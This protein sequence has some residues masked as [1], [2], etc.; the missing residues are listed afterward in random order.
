MSVVSVGSFDGVHAGHR[1]IMSRM[2]FLREE[3][4]IRGLG[5]GAK[6]VVVTFLP[7]P[8]HY[9]NPDDDFKLLN[10]IEEKARLVESCGIDIMVVAR[11]DEAFMNT[12]SAQ[13][14]D[15]LRTK[16]SMK[17]LMAGYNHRLGCDGVGGEQGL[18]ALSADY[19][20]EVEVLPEFFVGGHKVSSTVVRKAIISGDMTLAADLLGSPYGV[21]LAQNDLQNDKIFICEQ[22]LLPPDGFYAARVRD[23]G[24]NVLVDRL[25]AGVEGQAVA[26]DNHSSLVEPS[27]TNDK[28]VLEFL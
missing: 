23:L 12:T 6:T 26:L 21:E 18:K 22:K 27:A 19:G 7:H 24:G 20:V 10:T 1:A 17:V 11:F 9:I 25:F 28:I 2:N 13:F 16:L 5:G 8:R 14:F 4:K 3:L 15:I